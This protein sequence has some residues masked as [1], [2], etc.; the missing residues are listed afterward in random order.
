MQIVRPRR[1]IVAV[2]DAHTLAPPSGHNLLRHQLLLFDVHRAR[3]ATCY[4]SKVYA[5]E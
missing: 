3:S 2:A 1:L 5:G 4:H